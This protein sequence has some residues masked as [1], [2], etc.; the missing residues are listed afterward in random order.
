MGDR[1]H[2]AI[3]AAIICHGR[4]DIRTHVM[5]LVAPK[6]LVMMSKVTIMVHAR[7]PSHA[8]LAVHSVTWFFRRL[9]CWAGF[10]RGRETQLVLSTG[11]S[12][13]RP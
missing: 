5:P 8:P 12:Q 7:G 6:G 11:L 9:A 1:R 13:E 2:I 10:S 3:T 4:L